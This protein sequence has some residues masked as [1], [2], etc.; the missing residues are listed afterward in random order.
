MNRWWGPCQWKPENITQP[1]TTAVT[2]EQFQFF[3]WSI[4]FLAHWGMDT[5]ICKE[6]PWVL[7]VP[8]PANPY[9]WKDLGWGQD[10]NPGKHRDFG[11]FESES[12]SVSGYPKF[13]LPKYIE[14]PAEATHLLLKS[15]N[16]EIPCACWY[17]PYFLKFGPATHH[18]CHVYFHSAYGHKSREIP[19]IEPIFKQIQHFFYPC[20]T[21][22]NIG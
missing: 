14:N 11:H 8:Y 6:K 12:I 15:S 2:T 17:I 3:I 1:S 5:P 21:N 19:K 13:D 18:L 22:P 9:Y 4:G 20:S 16:K 10:S 7:E